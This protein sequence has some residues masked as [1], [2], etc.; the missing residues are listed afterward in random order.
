MPKFKRVDL[1]DELRAD[2]DG[3]PVFR[4]CFLHE[5]LMSFYDGSGATAFREWWEDTRVWLG[6]NNIPYDY[7]YMRE[8]GDRRKG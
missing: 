7:M 2:A 4:E 3:M 5:V 6:A 1:C 8:E